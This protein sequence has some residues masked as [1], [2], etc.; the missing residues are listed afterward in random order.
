MKEQLDRLIQLQQID[1]RLGSLVQEKTSI[2]EK[3]NAFRN[4]VEE[5]QDRLN[6]NRSEWEACNKRKRDKEQDLE[7]GEAQLSK[8]RDRQS[9]IKTNKE[10][11]A[12]LQEIESLALEK[13]RVE[14]AL[15]MVM[16]ELDSIKGREADLVKSFQSAE[17]EFESAKKQLEQKAEVLEARL[18][19]IKK[20]RG[21]VVSALDATL[22]KTY[23]KLT[24]Q[25]RGLAVVP[26][27]NGTCSGCHMNLPPQRVAEAKS[28]DRIL[29]CSQ[30][31][32]ILYWP[33]PAER[34]AAVTEAGT[35]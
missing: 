12:H 13:G 17:Q 11:Q 19:E 3:I 27:Q 28:R 18:E 16:E 6:R 9:G 32:R 2:P 34:P 29:T 23:Q 20:E 22:L 25:R 35:P 4:S 24:G 5:A 21:G 26:I 7:S 10:Y 31:L 14:E 1:T 8:A 15:L 33:L 30:C